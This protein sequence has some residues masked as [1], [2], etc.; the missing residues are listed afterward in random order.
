M[1]SESPIKEKVKVP[2]EFPSIEP[3][4]YRIAL[5]GECPGKDEILQG[6]PFVGQSGRMLD[7]CLSSAGIVRA[8]CFIGN[9][10]QTFRPDIATAPFTDPEIQHGLKVLQSDLAK[11]KPNLCVLLGKTALMAAKGV[12]NISDWR[13]S[14]FMSDRLI[15]PG[16][17]LLPPEVKCIASWHPAYCLR[18]YENT[19]LL[20]WDLNKA[21]EEGKLKEWY[22]PVY[23]IEIGLTCDQ[24]VERLQDV[25][26]NKRIIGCDIEGGV[27]DIS[28]IGIATSKVKAFVIPFL[29]L[30]GS[31]W[32]T[33]E[34]EVKLWFWVAKI[35]A[36]PAIKKTW[37]SGLY[38]RFVKQFSQ[39][40]LI[41]GNEDD[42]LLGFWEYAC[43]LPKDLGFQCSVLTRQPY[44]KA[45]R[46]TTDQSTFLR[47]CG[48]DAI[49]TF[50]I[51]EK[52]KPLLPKESREHY[53][54]NIEALNFLL[55]AELRGIR[56]DQQEAEKRLEA[57]TQEIG[58]LQQ[59]LDEIAGELRAIPQIDW[60]Q[61]H[62]QIL[63]KVQETCCHKRDQER[64]KK[65]YEE[66]Y[67]GIAES[68]R[69]NKPIDD[70]FRVRV[71]Q[72]L[73]YTLNIRSHKKFHDFLYITCGLPTQWKKDPTTKE[74]KRTAN[75]EAILKLS[76]SHDHSVIPIVKSMALHLTRGKML[77]I[78]SHNGRMHCSY[79]LV[80]SETAR[81]TSS[82]SVI[83]GFGKDRVGTNI[84][85]IPDDWEIEDESGLIAE[86]LRDLFLADEGC[87]LGKCDLKG[88]DG[89][90][91]ASYM[92]LLGDSTM[93]DDLQYG[94]KPPQ[95][96][97]Y[98]L[99]K[100]ADAYFK[101]ASDRQALKETIS[102]ISKEMWEYFVSKQGFY[103]SC[104]LMGPV[105]LGE[106]VFV[107]SEGKVNLNAKQCK[108]FQS[109]IKIRYKV[110]LWHK[111]MT[112]FLTS[113]PYPAKL[114]APNGFTRKFF[115]RNGALKGQQ[116]EI[117]GEALAHMPQ[118]ITTAAT[119]KAAERGWNDYE[120]RTTNIELSPARTHFDV[121]P[122]S[123]EG[124]YFRIEVAL[125]QQHDELV[126]QWLKEDTT[127]AIGKIHQWFENDIEVVLPTDKTKRVKIK[128][129]FDGQYGLNWA[130]N[131]E[132][133]VGNI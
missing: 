88:A 8:S 73:G 57:V 76:K 4:T 11:F 54:D 104:Y 43:E 55:Y 16:T 86:G 39:N 32:W 67:P 6:K 112:K 92:H 120:N 17:E 50:E 59:K 29:R 102:V 35:M 62:E 82:K 87:Y 22:P 78:K 10:C 125:H 28:C 114:T 128:V 19:P 61:P 21:K 115:G 15:D 25:Y 116:C 113:Q 34:E 94:I 27:N 37:Q 129:P 74:M 23:D 81:V 69:S 84:Q 93:L 44:Y 124:A 132:G 68:L 40:I 26:E 130:M 51:N 33:L 108:D 127:W 105:K 7:K 13:G 89:W 133:K 53:R 83:G 52:L 118:V 99:N 117:L 121:R 60:T 100:G 3:S 36:D 24:Y 46:K 45:D 72:L 85:T 1:I 119:N 96:V 58:K 98:I 9:V 38:D 97:A 48:T 111:W 18:Q 75:Y 49:V 12:K 79:N 103:G 71:S 107:E 14:F 131:K 41:R 110:D 30:D 77:S 5:I 66:D 109:A 70:A 126:F 64:P 65:D 123:T 106:R 47:Y 63:K 80:G 90:T 122:T 31:H 56:Y 42:T 91:V 95:V 20:M 101:V 2:N